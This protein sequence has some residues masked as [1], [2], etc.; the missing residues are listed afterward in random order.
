MA[1]ATPSSSSFPR[2][3]E[4][5]DSDSRKAKTLDSGSSLRDVRN[6]EQKRSHSGPIPTRLGNVVNFKRGY[7]LPE[8]SR[9]PGPYPVISSAGIS[10]YHDEF[11]CRG[12]GLVTGRYG[13]L[14]EMHYYDG[15]Y[16]PHNTALYVTDFKGNVPKYVYYLLSCLGQMNTGDKS[17]V[18]GVNR[19]DLHELSIPLIDDTRQ[20]QKIASV[21]SAL[22][23]KIDLN[24]RINAELEALA[25][26]VYDY[27]FV[28]FDFPD[29][30]GR[31]YKSSG[32]AMVWN[33]ALKREIPAGW[34]AV[35]LAGLGSFRN[36]INYDPSIGGDATARIVNVRNVSASTVFI[37]SGDLDSL[38]LDQDNIDRYLV[39]DESILIARSGIPGATR[40]MQ[41][42][43]PN[44]IYS[45]FII[46]LTVDEPL[47]KLLL[48]FRLKQLESALL[49]QSS[50][51]ILKNVSQDTLKEV[52]VAL[53]NDKSTVEKFNATVEPMFEKVSSNQHESR[54]L[55][56]LRDWLLP[57]LM[58]G[59]VR[60]GAIA[61]QDGFPLSRE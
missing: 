60:V 44:T 29:A 24:Q 49:S 54:E 42:C 50:G 58:N 12:E 10:G 20:Q 33:D 34:S 43:P 35:P 28:Q 17:A 27:W 30:N 41:P 19:N 37:E 38:E 48:F 21:L 61:R 59:Q 3:R 11:K 26:T 25:K 32:G 1:S 51:S 36:G 18:P 14:G 31:P 47:H 8:A 39:T 56:A 4:S 53:P 9:R 45:G 15:K 40:M 22:D 55:S 23:A 5:S 13:T 16:W 2:K 57:L 6:D 7:D 52:S 46:G